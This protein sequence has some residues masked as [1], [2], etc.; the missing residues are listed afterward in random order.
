M[1]HPRMAQHVISR[2]MR[3]LGKGR[4]RIDPM[5][6]LRKV[7]T[8]MWH[9]RTHTYIVLVRFIPLQ[10]LLLIRISATLSNMNDSFFTG[11]TGRNACFIR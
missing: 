4:T 11:P 3:A 6:S 7:V 9:V 1:G 2:G 5:I 10:G 8:D